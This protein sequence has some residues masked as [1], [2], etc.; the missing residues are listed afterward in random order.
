MRPR[1]TTTPRHALAGPLAA[2]AAALAALSPSAAAITGWTIQEVYTNE[3]G[4]IQFLELY[5]ESDSQ[6]ELATEGLRVVVY[7]G[8][9]STEFT[10]PSNLPHAGTA[11]RT[12]L[13]GTADFAALPVPPPPDYALDPGVRFFDPTSASVTIRL[14]DGGMFP[15]DSVT[16]AAPPLTQ[17]CRES[18]QYPGPVLQTNSPENFD[19]DTS[20]PLACCTQ[21]DECPSDG[22]ACTT[23]A[24]DA[25]RRTCS[26]PPVEE[27]CDDGAFCNGA[28]ICH[29][30]FDCYPGPGPCA[31]GEVCDEQLDACAE[32]FDDGDCDDGDACTDDLC[33]AMA[34]AHDALPPP[35][36]VQGLTLGRVLGGGPADIVLHW[37]AAPGAISYNVYR[38]RNPDLA[39]LDCFASGIGGTS[40]ISSGGAASTFIVFLVG[41]AGCGP[42]DLG[43]NR[44]PAPACDAGR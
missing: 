14:E 41:A 20:F 1:T 29:P 7:E 4:S 5:T 17:E 21:D 19:G 6:D 24:C 28:E 13:I 11:D 22:L 27:V 44:P 10:F 36:E 37:S 32:C 18:L 33:A 35:D 9:G 39:D 31:P 12:V 42:V 43:A 2:A 3:D 15:I 40:T 16:F 25:V 30:L 34:C 26:Y 8:T 38:G 23:V